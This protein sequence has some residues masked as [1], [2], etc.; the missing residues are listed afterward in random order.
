MGLRGR[1]TPKSHHETVS[2]PGGDGGGVVVLRARDLTIAGRVS[3]NGQEGPHAEYDA[4]G[5]GSGGGILLHARQL[6]ITGDVA[7]EGGKG[8]K[9]WEV[10]GAGGGG[11]IKIAAEQILVDEDA[12]QVSAGQGPCPGDAPSPY[13]C[14]GSTHVTLLPPP[15]YLPRA[16][17]RACMTRSAR[18]VVVVMDTSV[19]MAS[20]GAGGTAPLERAKAAAD[21]LLA[22][23][24]SADRA[25][26]VT[27]AGAA[28][29][30]QPLALGSAAARAALTH[31]PVGEGSRLDL[32]IAEGAK[33][34]DG[35]LPAEGR[36]MVLFTDGNLSGAEPNDALEAARAAVA[37]G[38]RLYAVGYGDRLD[39]EEL[40]ALVGGT[41]RLWIQPEPAGMGAVDSKMRADLPCPE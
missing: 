25:G 17:E 40:A 13:G 9:G 7:A 26:V 18:A 15:A 23:L 6:T 34:L 31:L 11:R 16:L 35:A 21:A 14:P 37:R 20:P 8:G 12:L 32:G 38:N 28:Q 22:Q 33:V 5:G 41:E 4:G 36:Q 10:G 27:F 39:A 24:G 3:A 19:S 1:S 30:V 29:T 2:L